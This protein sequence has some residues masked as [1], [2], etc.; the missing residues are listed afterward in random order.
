MDNILQVLNQCSD[1]QIRTPNSIQPFGTSIIIDKSGMI[2]HLSNNISSILYLSI[3]IV[4]DSI[5]KYFNI[6]I[7]NLDSLTSSSFQIFKSN[8]QKIYY[9]Y[10]VK[11]GMELYSIEIY[12][13]QAEYNENRLES[14]RDAIS[15]SN[16]LNDFCSK[17]V[18]HI[19]ELTHYDRV[20]IYKFDE[21]YN[22][23]VIS[24]L[25]QPYMES[26]MGHHFPADDIP[27]QA[28]ALYLQNLIRI[29]PNAAYTPV[30]FFPEPK[31][32]LD[33]THS[34]LRSVSPIHCQYLSNMNVQSSMSLSL[35]VNNSLWGLIACHSKNEHN[36]HPILRRDLEHEISSINKI[37]SKRVCEEEDY[38]EETLQAKFENFKLLIRSNHIDKNIILE[39]LQKL[40]NADGVIIIKDKIIIKN[41]NIPEDVD[42]SKI[43]T[44][45]SNKNFFVSSTLSS[46][47]QGISKNGMGIVFMKINDSEQVIFFRGEMV[48][49]L[50][51][52]GK[53]DKVV[54]LH[55]EVAY[56]S[57]RESFETFKKIEEGKSV[58]WTLHELNIA[59][60]LRNEM[61]QII[62]QINI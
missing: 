48:E 39:N 7:S 29:I 4:G 17:V 5:T 13:D 50:L 60:N 2:L 49:T 37:L 6:D 41:G 54:K 62:N 59:K 55:K 28:R 57:P 38:E 45:C 46:Y 10:I 15:S 56:I 11:L 24:E 12:N 33:M 58:P 47:I 52:A 14:F 23:S 8:N 18:S 3:N 25:K 21:N 34:T 61:Q 27:A 43:L 44:L 31:D 53:P 40:I 35:I 42:I 9:G 30:R 51:W 16:N 20:M 36:I 1:E 22:G 32:F 19:F 26:Y